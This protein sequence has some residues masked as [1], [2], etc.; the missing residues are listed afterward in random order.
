MTASIWM[1]AFRC[2][3]GTHSAANVSPHAGQPAIVDLLCGREGGLPERA[4]WEL[5]HSHPM[6]EL[7]QVNTPAPKAG[8]P[9]LDLVAGRDGD[10]VILRLVRRSERETVAHVKLEGLG[11]RRLAPQ[12]EDFIVTRESAGR[13]EPWARAQLPVQG[14]EVTVALQDGQA[15]HL[16]VLRLEGGQP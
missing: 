12:A 7:L 13:P 4:V 15:A 9:T 14:N 5:F 11:N 16:V 2:G 8:P 1:A 10:Q 6:G 3:W